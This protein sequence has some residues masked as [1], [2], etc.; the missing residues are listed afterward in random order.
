MTNWA[1]KVA[2]DDQFEG[3]TIFVIIV[4]ALCMGAETFPEL[5][6]PYG[7]IF[8]Y[9]FVASQCFFV[10][11]IAI[12]IFSYLPKFQGFFREP[13]NVFDFVVVTASF[14]PV[15]GPLA[16]TARLLRVLRVLRILSVSDSLRGFVSRISLLAWPLFAGVVVWGILSYVFALSGYYLLGEIDPERWGSLGESFASV[17]YLSLMQDLRLYVEP[18][19]S[20]E[21]GMMIYFLVFFIAWC[22]LVLHLISECVNRQVTPGAGNDN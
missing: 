14:L 20:T 10:A 2:N 16:L 15:V 7:N 4:N 12:R 22:S 5:S 3:I 1:R 8:Y 19:R 17:F 13:W 18:I 6:D 11:E 21:P 9:V